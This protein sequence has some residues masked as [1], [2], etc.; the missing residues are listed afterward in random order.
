MASF[1]N[2]ILSPNVG[3]AFTTHIKQYM[4]VET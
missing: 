1:R 4:G 2:G 3:S